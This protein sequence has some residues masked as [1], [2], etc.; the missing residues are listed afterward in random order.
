MS[1]GPTPSPTTGAVPAS[2]SSWATRPT[3]RSSPH[4]PPVAAPR[5]SAAGPTP[6]PP[7]SSSPSPCASPVP[8]AGASGWCCRSRSS[9]RVTSGRSA[10]PS[11]ATPR[12]A[13]RGSRRDAT[14]TPTSSCARSASSDAPMRWPTTARPTRRGPR[15]SPSA[16]GVPA[17]PP[18][19]VDGTLGE[20]ATASANFRDEYYGLAPGVGDHDSGPPLLTSGL[21]DPGRS[22][23][24]GR[25]ARY[26]GRSLQRPRVDVAALS[27]PMRRWVER[28]LVP[29][30]LVANQTAGDRGGGRPRRRV[31]AGGAGGDRDPRARV[32]VAVDDIAAV[33]T[34]PVASVWAW[35]RAA[36]AGLSARS[37]RV[38]PRLIEAVPWP[39]G[40]LDR[41][42]AR[43]HAGDVV[44]CGA[45][46]DAAFGVTS[47]RA[48][49]VVAGGA[50][51][52]G[53]RG[54]GTIAQ[55]GLAARLAVVIR[56]SLPALLF[57]G[58]VAL[59]VAGCGGDDGGDAGAPSTTAAGGGGGSTPPPCSAASNWPRTAAA[60]RATSSR[61]PASG[62]RG[63]GCTARP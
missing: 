4:A 14:S 51:R 21:I 5:P 58:A 20:R 10:P 63:S 6:M 53:G 34:S 38:G 8:A 3:C 61:A 11:T 52:V 29:K 31:A 41:A 44:G 49:V 47:T 32:A 25:S 27:A 12:C 60:S 13:G 24:G 50:A 62:R 30:V 46:V 28:L 35:H 43:L 55:A 33:L 39:A 17:L 16:S 19:A 9:A 45:A 26:A 36:G 22:N 42:V 23:W 59:G 48:R 7:A 54:E 37:L 56:R 18:L 57:V 40:A 1:F 15:W 2:T